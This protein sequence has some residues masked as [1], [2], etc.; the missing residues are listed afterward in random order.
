MT[1]C[2]P[3]LQ[4]H[5]LMTSDGHAFSANVET[6]GGLDSSLLPSA[7]TATSKNREGGNARRKHLGSHGIE[8]SLPVA[9]F[10][11]ERGADKDA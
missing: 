5:Y 10:L 11:P 2:A 6:L 1:I 7:R 3:F 8:L 4:L 9:G